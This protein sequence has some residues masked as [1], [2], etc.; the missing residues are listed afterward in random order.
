LRISKEIAVRQ[1][2]ITARC[3]M[4]KARSSRIR[5]H[6][7]GYK[8]QSILTIQTSLVAMLLDLY[9]IRLRYTE[10]RKLAENLPTTPSQMKLKI[11]EE[12]A[13]SYR[14]QTQ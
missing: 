5:Q 8:S 13:S 4:I 6:N 7:G 10:A 14:I 3:A 2:S 1:F 9:K 11:N 12:L